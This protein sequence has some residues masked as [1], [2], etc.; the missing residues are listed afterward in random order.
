MRNRTAEKV[1]ICTNSQ[2]Q[3]LW[4]ELSYSVFWSRSLP[5]MLWSLPSRDFQKVKTK[6]QLQLCVTGFTVGP[7][8]LVAFGLF[9]AP[10]A[11]VPHG[12]PC[13]T[14][15]FFWLNILFTIHT[16]H[17]MC[18]DPVH[19]QLPPLKL[20]LPFLVIIQTE[21]FMDSFWLPTCQSIREAWSS[22]ILSPSETT[23]VSDYLSISQICWRSSQG[24]GRWRESQILT[25]YTIPP[26]CLYY[27]PSISW[28]FID[29]YVL[30]TGLQFS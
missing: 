9:S 22:F 6:G 8:Q 20:Y 5:I 15:L 24:S 25:Q 17:V 10:G 29:L 16:S 1:G 28:Q 26:H 18:L 30:C 2:T 4:S 11:V 21:T 7:W 19:P 13:P 14:P 12:P 23:S 3:Q 27:P